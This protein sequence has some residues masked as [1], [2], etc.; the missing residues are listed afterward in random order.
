MEPLGWIYRGTLVIPRALRTR[1][2][3]RLSKQNSYDRW[4]RED[5]RRE[6]GGQ[7]A[8]GQEESV[9]SAIRAALRSQTAASRAA[10]AVWRGPPPIANRAVGGMLGRGQELGDQAFVWRAIG[11]PIAIPQKC[12]CCPR[13][14]SRHVFRIH[15]LDQSPPALAYRQ[16]SCFDQLC[17]GARSLVPSPPQRTA[18]HLQRYPPISNGDPTPGAAAY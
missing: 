10:N 6:E 1:G 14:L 12:N 7:E 5:S 11:N 13:D 2:T 3:L 4:C 16:F 17:L 9:R 15:V 8:E 18:R